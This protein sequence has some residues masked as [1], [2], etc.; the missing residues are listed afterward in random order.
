M[1]K[2]FILLFFC[3]IFTNLKSQFQ[4]FEGLVSA[5]DLSVS[6][7]T[8]TNNIWQKG[9]PQKT[10]FSSASTT[11]NVIV[12]D[13]INYYPKNNISS[14]IVVGKQMFVAGIPKL[15]WKQKLNMD[16]KKD[17][18][19]VEFSTNSGITWQNAHNNPN[20]YQFYGFQPAN[21]DTIN[22][23]E[24]CFSG[25]DNVWRDIWLCLP[26]SIASLNDTIL[27]RFTFKSDTI[28]TN[29]EGWMID[30]FFFQNTIVHP[31]K[32]ISNID[33]LVVYPNV[34]NG[35]IN[36]EMKKTSQTDMIDNIELVNEEGKIIERYGQNYTK[37]VLD[38]SNH[39]TGLY[40]LKV[41]INKKVNKFK[42]LY[43]KN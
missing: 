7:S 13:T 23:N 3:S 8:S 36:V 40:Y 4:Y 19:I 32:E 2:L 37:V 15:Q 38:I 30:N 5:Y 18:G 42:I 33:D 43:E 1:Q 9:R 26:Y 17:G 21:K 27:Y 34:T 6:I 29:K 35:I 14:F 41:T 12:T 39:K 28:N 25:T 24:Y 11:P 20:V 16:A 31:V 10:L 22:T